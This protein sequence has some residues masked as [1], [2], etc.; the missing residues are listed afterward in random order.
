MDNMY[1]ILKKM[2]LQRLAKD[3]IKGGKGDKAKDKDFSPKEVK[4][5]HVVEGEHTSSKELAAE[6]T[7]DHLTEDPKYYSKLKDAGL[8][9]ELEKGQNGDWQKEGYQIRHEKPYK[10][11]GRMESISVVSLNGVDVARFKFAYSKKNNQLNVLAAEVHPDHQRKGIATAVYSQIE[12][13]TNLKLTPTLSQTQDA[14]ALW[15][16]P[17]RPFGKSEDLEKGSFQRRYPF[18]PTDVSQEARDAVESWIDGDGDRSSIPL[19]TGND[20]LRAIQKLHAVAPSRRN[21]ETGEREFLLH[22]GQSTQDIRNGQIGQNGLASFTPFPK[23]AAN[24]ANDALINQL[25]LRPENHDES[26][27]K[28]GNVYSAWIPESAI[29]HIPNQW[30]TAD[31]TQ[32]KAGGYRS[33]YEVI[34]KTPKLELMSTKHNNIKHLI[35]LHE[36]HVNAVKAD[37]QKPPTERY[38]KSED[39]NGSNNLMHLEHYSSQPDLKQIDPKFHGTGVKG[40]E[41]KRKQNPDWVDRS[42]HYVAGTT[43]ESMVGAMPHKY[44]SSVPKDKI[45]DYQA[46]PLNLRSKSMWGNKVD[47][48][49]YEKNIKEAGYHGYI[50]KGAPGMGS[51]VALF[52][53]VQAQKIEKS[54]ELLKGA[55]RIA[56]KGLDPKNTRP[57]QDVKTFQPGQTSAKFLDRKHAKLFPGYPAP[58]IDKDVAGIFYPSVTADPSGESAQAFAPAG[59]HDVIEHEGHHALVDKLIAVHGVD[60]IYNMYNNLLQQIHPKVLDFVTQVARSNPEYAKMERHPT[61]RY[62]LAHKEELVNMIRDFVHG[63]GPGSRRE[64][65]N[66]ALDNPHFVR[67]WGFKTGQEFDTE[68][69]RAWKTIRDGANKMKPEDLK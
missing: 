10:N 49:T 30:G 55:G 46:D 1:N 40:E 48:N 69:K 44:T 50:N 17:N 28:F 29:H 64:Q 61:T 34:A 21:P 13:K 15:A 11:K 8:A 47:P 54:E 63:S 3:R 16:Q 12:K 25:E 14:K 24:F 37:K 39:L 53:P 18:N 38:K 58:S 31:N 22:R 5:G 45:Y 6:I 42:Y 52:H 9:D 66:A 62:Q 59:V 23:V 56:P 68:V 7:R 26:L 65:W 4:M 35:D 41:S 32:I 57:D 20:R 67:N 51:V 2:K 60:K 36:K 27:S 19:M 43:P 33:E